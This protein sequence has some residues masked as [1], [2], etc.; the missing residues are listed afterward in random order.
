MHMYVYLNKNE[1][2]VF[3]NLLLS[4]KIFNHFYSHINPPNNPVK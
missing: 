1:I 2:M 4:F 3:G